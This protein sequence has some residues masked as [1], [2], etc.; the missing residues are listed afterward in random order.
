MTLTL[1]P[2]GVPGDRLRVW[3]GAFGAANAPPLTW[4]LNGAEAGPVALSAL[5]SV[6]PDGPDG[7]AAPA[8]SRV[9]A[10]VYEFRGLQPGTAYIAGVQSGQDRASL[11]ARTLPAE[12]PP[13]LRRP[14][15]VLLVSCYHQAEDR[16]GLAGAI[17]SQ[18]TGPLAPDLTLLMGDQ[19]Y[20]DLPTLANFPDDTVALATKFEADYVRNWRGPGGYA[21]V[22]ASAP[23]VSI[24]D[25]HEYWNNF[26]HA[27]P[28]IQNSWTEAGRERWRVAAEAMYAGFQGTGVTAPGSPAVLEVPP[29]SFFFADTRS[30]RDPGR[31]FAMMASDPIRRAFRDWAQGVVANRR[32]GVL[33]TGQPIF[34]DP[35]W[36]PVGAVGDYGLPDYGDY[37]EI[38]GAL[39]DLV[40]AGRPLL[41][42]TGD[43]HWGRLTGATDRRTGRRVVHEI[44]SSPSSLVTTI[45]ADDLSRLGAGLGRLFGVREPWPRHSNP[46][47]A[48]DYLAPQVLEKRFACDTLHGQR[49]NHVALLSFTVKGGGLELRA[50]YWPLHRELAER[51]PVMLPPITLPTHV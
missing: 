44:I 26:P 5:R 47:P 49:G 23:S 48:P 12:V 13:S 36:G 22:L 50:S 7:M 39:R 41:C 17:V 20:L 25:D 32:V 28:W 35:V 4:T 29:L 15:N 45:M 31:R 43:V 24:P 38:V 30:L 18:L 46:K 34:A 16:S 42:L 3:V 33:V 2:R 6:R 19:V 27:E 40:D 14:F 1:H 51:R 8:A 9:F 10:G 11:S 37:P 21:Q